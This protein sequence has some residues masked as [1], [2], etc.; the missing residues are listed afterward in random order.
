MGARR[1]IWL[2]FQP[3]LHVET[4]LGTFEYDVTPHDE[5]KSILKSGVLI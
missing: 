2:V 1:I 4:R 3:M 5:Q